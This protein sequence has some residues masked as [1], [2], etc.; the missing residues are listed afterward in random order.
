MSASPWNDH[1]AKEQF[2]SLADSLIDAGWTLRDAV[3]DTDPIDG[4]VVALED[5]LLGLE[6]AITS[7]WKGI[8][9][10]EMPSP[11]V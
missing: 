9:N 8:S 5:S 3:P 1:A 10:A 4:R 11:I 2:A 6:E 7:L